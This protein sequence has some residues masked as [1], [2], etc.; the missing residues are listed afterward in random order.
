MKKRDFQ[1]V[2]FDF[3][4]TLVDTSGDIA[5]VVNAARVSF[6]LPEMEPPEIIRFVGHGI[7]P[8]AE[9]VFRHTGISPQEAVDRMMSYYSR[10]PFDHSRLYPG[11]RE[12]LPE[13]PAIRT[14]VS[15]KPRS[16]IVAALSHFQI[17][18]L[19]VQV[20]GGDTFPRRKP[21]PMALQYLM[22]RYEAAAPNTLV[23][24]DHQPDIEMARAAGAACAYC[25]YGFFGS[26]ALE[27][28]YTL[29][30]FGDLKALF[31]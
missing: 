6:G 31:S 23:V 28:D 17:S 20:I 26:T 11:V 22:G 4:G 10:R 7:V 13:I 24:G 2:A 3:D 5:A 16:L 9:E 14:I 8:L 30:H 19:F 12:L 1:L 15:N 18:E 27:C 21:D 25:R 29:D